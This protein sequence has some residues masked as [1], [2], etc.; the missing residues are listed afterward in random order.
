[1]VHPYTA[2]GGSYN[3]LYADMADRPHLLIAG[4]TGSGKST[5][6]DGIMH[7]ILH[8]TPA[9]SRMILI[10]LKMVELDDYRH[11]PHVITYADDTPG[12]LQALQQ[13]LDIIM[14]R[15]ADMQ[16]RHIKTYDG[17]HVYVIIDELADLMTTAAK[18]AT[19]IL[20][21]ITQIG[22]GAC[23]HLIAATQVPIS[24]VI[25][26]P[27]KVNFTA[28]LGLMTRS[29]QD[30]RNIIYRAGCEKLP[31]PPDA[32]TAYGYYLRGPKLELYQIPRI[33]DADRRR[34]IDHWTRQTITAG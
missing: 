33:D 32:G 8:D 31:Y 20:Q 7:A 18:E 12:A 15:Y 27:I 3:R 9:E 34:I 26:T 25:P 5:V 23:C 10:D 2:P 4:A 1:M 19:P 22:R 28:S 24:A 11:L 14:A 16:R 13:A 17:S 6:I 29:A 21:R 30:S